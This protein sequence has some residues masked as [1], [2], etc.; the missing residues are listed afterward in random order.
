[1]FEVSV[2]KGPCLLHEKDHT[3]REQ[4][5]SPSSEASGAG[6]RC[7]W[8]GKWNMEQEVLKGR[9]ATL[10]VPVPLALSSGGLLTLLLQG[11]ERY[12]E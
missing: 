4:P 8:R 7:S 11:T 10:G 3:F 2:Q 12:R 6:G 9:Q 1:M 5:H